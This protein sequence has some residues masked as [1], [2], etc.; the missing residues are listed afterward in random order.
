MNIPCNTRIYTHRFYS[1]S[2]FG[3][4]TTRFST[5]VPVNMAIMR[6]ALHPKSSFKESAPR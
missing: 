4:P 5:S 3:F 1:I 2:P 6:S